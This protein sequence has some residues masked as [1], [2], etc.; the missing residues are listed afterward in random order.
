MSVERKGDDLL[1]TEDAEKDRENR[2]ELFV[3]NVTE[4]KHSKAR[5]KTAFTKT[6]RA[7][8]VLILQRELTLDAIQEACVTLDMVQEEA[9]EAIEKLLDRF[10]TEKDYKSSK[11][12]G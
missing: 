5:A 3:E 7:L 10:R 2:I 1:L 4:L 9:M 11:R 8:L 12:L 6:M